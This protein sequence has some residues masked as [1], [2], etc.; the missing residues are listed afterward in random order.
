[1]E[2]FLK[3]VQEERE[4]DPDFLEPIGD[5]EQTFTITSG[6]SYP[7]ATMTAAIT[8]SYLFT[9][10]YVKW[11]EIELD[12]DSHSAENQVWSP[13]AKALQNA[14]LRYLNN[15]RLDHALTLRK[16]GR[17]ESLR[18]FLRKVWKQA[19]TEKQFDSENALLLADELGQE[20][21]QAEQE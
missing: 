17:L 21:R 10:I 7:S 18:G 2:E 9:D 19:S 16:E 13:F 1:V 5:D 4:Q 6:A 14:P 11:R 8:D 12:R 20:I 3:S 15:L